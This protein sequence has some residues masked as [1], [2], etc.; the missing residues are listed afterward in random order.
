MW[1]K[2]ARFLSVLLKR[3]MFLRKSK[4]SAKRNTTLDDDIPVKIMKEM[5]ISSRITFTFFTPMQ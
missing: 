4:T 1:I 5:S 3:S 2:K